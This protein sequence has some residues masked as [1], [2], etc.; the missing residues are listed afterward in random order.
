[1]FK[2]GD[3]L[4]FERGGSISGFLLGY[5]ISLAEE[6]VGEDDKAYPIDPD[7]ITHVAL[8]MSGGCFVEAAYDGI[9][10][11][12][13][14]QVGRVWVCSLK[15]ELS[16]QVASKNLLFDSFLSKQ[17]GQSYDFRAF[18]KMLPYLLSKR[19]LFKPVEDT[20]HFI[21]SELVSEALEI[22]GIQNTRR[23]SSQMTPSDVFRQDWFKERKRYG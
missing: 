19:K 23:N 21:C 20:R 7:K 12:P 9:R 2:P 1:M 17:L 3:I 14:S 18:F 13:L 10:V 8:V 22:V 4:C 16:E 15:D 6:V 5:L 11:K